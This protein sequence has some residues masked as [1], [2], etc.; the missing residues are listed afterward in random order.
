MF[1]ALLAFLSLFQMATSC[2]FSH[3]FCLINWQNDI[4]YLWFC[5]CAP[6]AFTHLHIAHAYSFLR[7][8]YWMDVAN[9]I[10]PSACSAAECWMVFRHAVIF[11]PFLFILVCVSFFSLSFLVTSC[12]LLSLSCS[13]ESSS[14]VGGRSW[15]GWLRDWL[16]E[17]LLH[18]TFGCLFWLG[19]LAGLL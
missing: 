10:L 17:C 13:L 19:F 2:G 1:I 12:L 8:H 5:M 16:R 14:N 18:Q 6:H 3:L 11:S 4:H 7:A 15:F 9:T